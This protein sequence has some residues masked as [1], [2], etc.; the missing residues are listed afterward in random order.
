MIPA[1]TPIAPATSEIQPIRYSAGGAGFLP[2]MFGGVAT[3]AASQSCVMES[4]RHNDASMNRRSQRL[5]QPGSGRPKLPAMQ[6]RKFFEQPFTPDRQAQQD[7]TTV[8]LT[9]RTANPTVALEAAAQFDGG[10]MLDLQL[11]G[12]CADGRVLASGKSLDGEKGL[13]LLRV[14]ARRASG[15]P[16]EM[17]VA[18]NFVPEARQCFIVNLSSDP[19]S[20]DGP[21]I[22]YYDIKAE[23]KKREP[24]FR[25]SQGVLQKSTGQ[26]YR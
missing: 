14:D 2:S 4:V 22:S 10:V 6:Q 17:Q 15:L 1:R 18:A 8:R 12:Q 7:F 21:I 16:A 9:A 13:I 5:D 19:L 25:E 24:I 20:H 11:L 23:A 26:G 3:K